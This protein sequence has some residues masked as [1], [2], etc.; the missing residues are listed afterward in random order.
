MRARQQSKHGATGAQLNPQER[1]QA[2]RA[3][4][5]SERPGRPGSVLGGVEEADQRDSPAGP[6]AESVISAR[7]E[8]SP[9][10]RPKTGPAPPRMVWIRGLVDRGVQE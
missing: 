4:A 9:V 8:L 1:V 10:A 5:P 2:S 6:G 7:H 3:G